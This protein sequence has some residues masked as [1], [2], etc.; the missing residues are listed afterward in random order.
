M[1][2]RLGSWGSGG[3]PTAT[4]KEFYTN[5]TIPWAVIGDL[6]NA[7]L[8]ETSSK[9]TEK[10]LNVSSTKLIPVGAILIAMYGASIGKAA[11][12][13]IECCTNQAIAHCI[14][15]QSIIS[16]DYFMIV[17]KSLKQHLIDVG[18]GAAQPNISQTVLK[19]LLIDIPQPH[20]QDVIVRKVDEHMALCD[21]LEDQLKIRNMIAE[22]YSRAVVSA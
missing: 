5:G 21:Q 4:R 19:H 12:T 17:A 6:N 8:V 9:I 14:P 13:G 7:T 20:L 18:R 3:T 22:R 11:I 15:D 10:A 2:A 16:T 1:P